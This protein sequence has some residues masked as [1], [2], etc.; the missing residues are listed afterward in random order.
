MSNITNVK[1]KNIPAKVFAPNNNI[2]VF[3]SSKNTGGFESSKVYCKFA[4]LKSLTVNCLSN[5]ERQYNQSWNEDT[6]K[7]ATM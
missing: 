5:S 1:L 4:I 7:S 6:Y 2:D 3:T